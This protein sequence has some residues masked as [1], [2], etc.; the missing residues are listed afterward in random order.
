[1]KIDSRPQSPIPVDHLLVELRP[2]SLVESRI[3]VMALLDG[4][5]VCPTLKPQLLTEAGLDRVSVRFEH[6]ERSAHALRIGLPEV[7]AH[8]GP[9]ARGHL[10]RVVVNQ[11]VPWDSD[12][13]R[14]VLKLDHFRLRFEGQELFQQLCG[15][16]LPLVG[17]LVLSGHVP[18]PLDMHCC[19]SGVG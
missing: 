18:I 13:P 3:A 7:D 6:V 12:A 17:S 10:Q 4:C 9:A 2:V 14:S 11:L 15:K 8:D 1:M 5:T 16:L 19:A